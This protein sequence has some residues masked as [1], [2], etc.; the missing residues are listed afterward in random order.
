[1]VPRGE[2]TVLKNLVTRE[3]GLVAGGRLVSVARGEQQFFDPSGMPTAT[4]GCKSNALMRCCKDLG[5]ASE[6]WCGFSFCFGPRLS[7]SPTDLVASAGTRCSSARSRSST[8]S[9]H[10]PSTSRARRSALL[11]WLM[12]LLLLTRSMLY[13]Q[14]R[15]RKKGLSFEYPY[16]EAAR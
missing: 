3:W 10:G 15:W 4:E 2:M 16:S 8:A 13:R 5:I 9:R 7:Y 14:K 1:M 6:L 12:K 11:P